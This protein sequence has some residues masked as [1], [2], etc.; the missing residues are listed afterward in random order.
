MSEQ[1]RGHEL[2]TIAVYLV[3]GDTHGVDTEDV[4]I[5]VNELSPAE[6]VN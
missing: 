4:A 5:K 6:I 1:L 3:G 2:V